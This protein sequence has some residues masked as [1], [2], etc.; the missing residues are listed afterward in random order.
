MFIYGKMAADAIAVTSF[1]AGQPD[2]LCGTA[3]ISEDRNISRALTAKLFTRLATA[4]IAEGRPGPGGGYRLARKAE[5]ISLLQIVELFEQTESI[6]I[7]PFGHGWCGNGDPCPIHDTLEGME[8]NN[9][10]FLEETRLSVFSP[11]NALS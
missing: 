6:S 3:E 1:L 11:S 8:Q 9:R 7:C 10:R 5:D 2:R 4:G